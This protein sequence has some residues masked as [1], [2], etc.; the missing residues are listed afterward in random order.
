[1]EKYGIISKPYATVTQLHSRAILL[2][3]VLVYSGCHIMIV[4]I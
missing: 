3:F 4:M 1:M 2:Q